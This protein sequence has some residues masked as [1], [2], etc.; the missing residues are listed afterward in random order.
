MKRFVLVGEQLCRTFNTTAVEVN[1]S[2]KTVRD[3]DKE[4]ELTD[5]KRKLVAV[6]TTFLS[7]TLAF[8]WVITKK[9]SVDAEIQLNRSLAFLLPIS[10]RYTATLFDVPKCY[11]L[12]FFV[13]LANPVLLNSPP[14][15]FKYL[16]RKTNSTEASS[17]VTGSNYS[18]SSIGS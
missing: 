15:Y 8:P 17:A 6:S 14:F 16:G 4:R 12:P 13:Y 10:K 7:S 18:S 5:F 11:F 3:L 2:M 1:S 9:L